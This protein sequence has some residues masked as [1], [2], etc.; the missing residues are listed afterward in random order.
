MD[1]LVESSFERTN[2]TTM[3]RKTVPMAAPSLDPTPT[4]Q[5]HDEH[6]D[7]NDE[8]E[9]TGS[10]AV[11]MIPKAPPRAD[12]PKQQM[13]TTRRRRIR[14]ADQAMQKALRLSQ[15]GYDDRA[16]I[17]EAGPN[18]E[19]YGDS[20]LRYSNWPANLQPLPPDIAIHAPF[21]TGIET[22]P[23]HDLQ[24]RVTDTMNA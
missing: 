4:E 19:C 22:P 18:F 2:T 7:H 11:V 1:A 9:A 6:N 8:E 24:D 17:G 12:A 13:I 21:H 5:K 3:T 14:G 23:Y 15:G 10:I 16:V 20:S